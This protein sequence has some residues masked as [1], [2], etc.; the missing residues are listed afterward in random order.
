VGGWIAEAGGGLELGG[1]MSFERGIG[2]NS[3]DRRRMFEQIVAG[4]EPDPFRLPDTDAIVAP[5]Q[6]GDPV[7]QR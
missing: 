7:P 1:E 3:R 6:L 2:G 4:E 5:R